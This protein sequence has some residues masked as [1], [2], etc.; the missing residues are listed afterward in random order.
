MRARARGRHPSIQWR[1]RARHTRPE[2]GRAGVRHALGA[3]TAQRSA[4]NAVWATD[5]GPC[6]GCRTESARCWALGSQQRRRRHRA[7]R[8]ARAGRMARRMAWRRARS[9]AVHSAAYAV[10]RSS[11]PIIT[12]M[13]LT[14]PRGTPRSATPPTPLLSVGV[15]TAC[16]L[17][18]RPESEAADSCHACTAAQ[19]GLAR[20]AGRLVGISVR[21]IR[22]RLMV[23]RLNTALG[24]RPRGLIRSIR[25]W[26]MQFAAAG[27]RSGARNCQSTN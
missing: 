14:D 3:C 25:E 16:S 9:S 2:L 22:P 26:H 10:L 7:R 11:A 21:K 15:G 8:R 19:T 27:E 4:C 12:S 1:A 13:A 5:Q 6:P 17:C 23:E 24:R 18:C 20:S